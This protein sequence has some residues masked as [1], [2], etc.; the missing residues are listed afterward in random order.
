[1]CKTRCG[2]ALSTLLL[3]QHTWKTP[4]TDRPDVLLLEGTAFWMRYGSSVIPSLELTLLCS[5][6]SLLTCCLS[7]GLG[8]YC[9]TCGVLLLHC[10]TFSCYATPKNGERW[11][12]TI[13][14]QRRK[15]EREKHG[16][17]GCAIVL[18]GFSYIIV[19][20][21]PAM[22]PLKN[23]ERWNAAISQQ[24]RKLERSSMDTKTLNRMFKAIEITHH[25]VI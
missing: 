22:Q 6:L 4:D 12:A 23:G 5:G 25:F 17:F 24:R 10:A 7:F 8:M 15:L 21:S 16:H 1:M 9:C 20:I 2:R 3:D 11:N 13:S 14:Q 19:W 18:V